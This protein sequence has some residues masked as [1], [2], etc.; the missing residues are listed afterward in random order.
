MSKPRLPYAP[1]PLSVE[2][3]V[4][5]KVAATEAVRAV[6]VIIGKPKPPETAAPVTLGA[7]RGDKRATRL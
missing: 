4:E 7:S 3:E 6:R 1:K 2:V 5:P